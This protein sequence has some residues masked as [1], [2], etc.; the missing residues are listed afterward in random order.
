LVPLLPINHQFQFGELFGN[1]E[2]FLFVNLLVTAEA[3]ASWLLLFVERVRAEARA[4]YARDRIIHVYLRIVGCSP[5]CAIVLGCR[6]DIRGR[7][8]WVRGVVRVASGVLRKVLG[9]V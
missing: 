8:A 6:R 7:A 9:Q 5:S 4:A 1:W 2:H 3:G